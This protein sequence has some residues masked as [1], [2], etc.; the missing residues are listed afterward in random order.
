MTTTRTTTANALAELRDAA[1]LSQAEAAHEVNRR[2][3][4][5][6]GGVTANT[7]SRW[8]RG[9]IVPGPTYQR[10][11]ADVYGVT[12]GR[13][14]LPPRRRA[15]PPRPSPEIL[16]MDDTQVLDDPRVT[17][18]QEEWRRTRA[19]L[20]THR[21]TLT[22]LAAATYPDDA[23][24]EDTG[25]LAG[26]NWIPQQPIEIAEI[27]LTYQPHPPAPHIDGTEPES[28]HVRPCATVSRPYA[29]YTQAIRDL[30]HPRLFDNRTSW[31]LLDLHWTTST[32]SMTF[33]PTTYFAATDVCEALAHET[34]R[35]YLD[36]HGH[37][38][39]A[40][41][42]LRDL[43]LR[44]LVGHPFD[45]ARRPVLPSIDTLT[46][47]N[48]PG[49]PTFVLHNRSAGNVAVAGGTLHVMPCGV[50]QPSSLLPDAAGT[51]F[52]LWRNMA[53]EYSEEFLGNAEHGGDGQPADYTTSPLIDFETLRA[54]GKIRVY[55]LGVA[56]DALTLFGEILTVAVYD[57]DAYDLL[58]A[59]M[60]DANEEGT[61][62]KLAG[63]AT[64]LPFTPQAVDS[65][66]GTGRM[67]PAGAG[68]LKLA[69]QHRRL[70]LGG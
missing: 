11:L 18:S 60:V 27:G 45:L 24:L 1:R 55:C 42:N 46:I 38:T 41:P 70:M 9:V 51:D 43:P 65:I 69:L 26:P 56:L 30:A 39:G 31:R 61:V 5:G 35:V 34:A 16:L 15:T 50:F 32:G 20:N 29:R 53:R 62:A 64:A 40:Q 14:G 33:G 57:P 28:G 52:S 21:P 58:F 66:L 36:D 63:G 8:E 13:L 37:P 22:Q 19:A 2:A 6:R 23:R 48:A 49:S 47:R 4:N 3:K 17:A 25:L 68:C 44:R 54:A 59:E 67:A 12:I 7:I 10:V